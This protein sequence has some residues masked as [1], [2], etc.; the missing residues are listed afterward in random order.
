MQIASN[1][2]SNGGT[3]EGADL[4]QVQPRLSVF[5]TNKV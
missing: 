3:S 2:G 1:A 4:P 5:P